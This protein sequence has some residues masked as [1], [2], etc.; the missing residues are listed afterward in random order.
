MKTQELFKLLKTQVKAYPKGDMVPIYGNITGKGFF[1]GASGQL[2]EYGEKDIMILGHDFGAYSAYDASVKRGEENMKSLMW[3]NLFKVFDEYNINSDRCFLTNV[4]MGARTCTKETPTSSNPLYKKSKLFVE[5]CEHFLITQIDFQR[6]KAIIVLGRHLFKNLAHISTD[7]RELSNVKSF[8]ELD[9]K[10]GLSF[11]KQIGINGIEGY[12]TN[13][14]FIVH[15]SFRHNRINLNRRKNGSITGSDV[16]K[17]IV[18]A[19]I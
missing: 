4:I 11:K 9:K 3:I 7:L 17:K 6:P 16:E 14:G 12:K 1:P 15:P 13:I 10:V 18:N 8:V 2:E 5:E 19:I